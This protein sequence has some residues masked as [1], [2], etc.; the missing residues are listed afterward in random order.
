MWFAGWEVLSMGSAAGWVSWLQL[1]G[2]CFCSTL[3]GRRDRRVLF[4][5]VAQHVRIEIARLYV[6]RGW[7]NARSICLQQIN[8]T[9]TSY[10]CTRSTCI[11]THTHTL[12]TNLYMQ[13][14]AYV[15]NRTFI[16]SSVYATHLYIECVYATQLRICICN[17][18]VYADGC[19]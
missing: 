18:S 15:S 2:G 12:V 14:D 6:G 1:A 7:R 11:H 3:M 17:E 5:V 9:H 16:N 4:A 10:V 8:T 13:I 19:L